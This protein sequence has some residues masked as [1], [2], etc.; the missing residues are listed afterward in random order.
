MKIRVEK[1]IGD[2]V[3]SFE[4]GV[5][6]KQ[7]AASVIAQYGDTVVLNAVTNGPSRPGID[8]FALTCDYRE[9]QAAAGKF[10]GGFIKREGRPTTKE[11]LTSRL[12]DRPLRPMFTP[13]FMDE[14][15]IQA[16]VIASDR[17]HDSDVVA[18]NG[19]AAAALISPLPFHDPVASVRL[20]RLDGKWIVFPTN[21]ELEESELDLIVSGTEE[22]VTMIEGFAREM[23]ESLM[24]EAIEY[25]HQIVREICQLQRELARQ[26]ATRKSRF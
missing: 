1:Q 26:V 16:I 10:P 22:A 15:Q 11:T 9:R 6:A 19:S 25:S 24:A 8:F 5:W 7:A 20:G 23:P 3:L 13:G 4:T 17:Q 12:I 2:S 18:M 21:D 14:V